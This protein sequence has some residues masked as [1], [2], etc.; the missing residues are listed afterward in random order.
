MR[1]PISP[2][3]TSLLLHWGAL[4][5]LALAAVAALLAA[6]PLRAA[7]SWL[8]QAS[9]AHPVRAE[10]LADRA[11]VEPGGTVRLGVLLRMEEEWHTYWAFSGD[12]GLPTQ[13]EWRLPA[14]LEAGPLEWPG[15]HKYEEAGGLTVYG[16]ADSVLL[17]AEV[18]VPDTV[19][20][21]RRLQLE[22]AVSWLVC[23]HTCIPGDAVVTAS[24][25]VAVGPG[26]GTHADLFETQAGRVPTPHSAADPIAWRA[27]TAARGQGTELTV[28]LAPRGDGYVATDQYPDFYPLG[29]SS[30][31]LQVTGREV[32]AN[33]QVSVS[34][35]LQSY[36]DPLPGVLDGVLVYA[37]IDGG[38]PQYRS[39]AVGLGAPAAAGGSVDLLATDFARDNGGEGRPLVVYL[40]MA[41]LGGLLLNLMP[42]VLPVISLKVLSFVNQA[43]EEAARIRQL[44]LAFSAG[45]VA[46]FAA[47][48]LVVI[49]AKAG[50][51][52]LGWGFQFQSPGFVVFLAGLVFVLGLSLFGVVTV[53]LPGASGS[54]G[55]LAEREGL[56]GSFFNGVLATILATP[57]T[58]PFLGAALGFAFSQSAPVTASV[59]VAA[60]VGMAVPYLLLG[61]QP[62]W[63]RLLPQP[64]AW[65]E[66]FKQ[67]MGFPLMATVLWLLWVL[68]KQLGMEAVV[69]TGAFLLALALSSWVVGQWLDLRSSSRRRAVGWL[70]AVAI[71][72]ASYWGFV[73]PLLQ[74]EAYLTPDTSASADGL[75]WEPY[76]RQRTEA[77]LSAGRMVFI[78]FTAEW[79]WTCKVNERTVLADSRVHQRFEELDVAL[80]KADWTHRRPEITALLR[81]F[82]R[83]GVPLYVV[84]PPGRPGEPIVLPE[85]ITVGMLLDALDGAA[86]AGDASPGTP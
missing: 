52:G 61:L 23:R 68:G 85:I 4:W 40:L 70:V 26:A 39:I 56:G 83:S 55:G 41:A 71:S 14:G 30:Y 8:G 33:G 60:G 75:A 64:G 28:I 72:G 43:G 69:W 62:G 27:E 47:L 49:A 18:T 29:D 32:D 35:A 54:F 46:T 77:L 15:P 48:A 74:T 21:G 22:A 7:D 57:C 11:A 86:R 20:P 53:R 6:A 66:R 38:E 76:D 10:L 3:S 42:C 67:A 16:Y 81:A 59:F 2:I 25:P 9:G 63:T 36:G 44:G 37:P 17:F 73:H 79:C 5:M 84:F 50:G 34:L 13:V 12:A 80:I 78:D 24:L 1:N 51:E 45:I 19:E 82:G 58:A 65:M 31:G